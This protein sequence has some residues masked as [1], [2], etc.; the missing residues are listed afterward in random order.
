MN[1]ALLG[2]LLGFSMAGC[3]EAGPP[4][5][6]SQVQ[7]VTAMPGRDASVAYLTLHNHSNKPV[8]LTGITSP[9]FARVELHETVL[10]N[11]I[12]SMR[13]LT[14]LTLDANASTE[15]APGGKHVMLFEPGQA[16]TPGHGVTLQFHFASD[17]SLIVE[18]P[19]KSR[20]SIN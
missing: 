5:S 11:G 10:N 18:T 12:A 13:S 19:L 6:V 16:M 2:L 17:D 3:G 20:L 9:Q 15:L 4:L 14:S 1:K 8:T 7:V